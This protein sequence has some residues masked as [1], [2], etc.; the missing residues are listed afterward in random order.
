[1]GSVVGSRDP[2]QKKAGMKLP[3]IRQFRSAWCHLFLPT[4]ANGEHMLEPSPSSS[5]S[6]S[7]SIIINHQS[8]IIILIVYNPR[9]LSHPHLHPH[10][11]NY[12]NYPNPN[13]HHGPNNLERK[14]HARVIILWLSDKYE[15]NGMKEVCRVSPVAFWRSSYVIMIVDDHHALKTNHLQKEFLGVDD[16][17]EPKVNPLDH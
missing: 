17:S 12:W 11:S 1:M 7:S 13:S 10:F 9:H 16:H 5:S 8:S 2:S 15:G 4:Y 6:S 14:T 3:N